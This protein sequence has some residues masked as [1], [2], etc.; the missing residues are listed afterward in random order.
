MEANLQQPC[1][2]K[3]DQIEI[4]KVYVL[5]PGARFVPKDHELIVDHLMKKVMNEPVP[6]LSI[7]EI[8][9]A[10]HSPQELSE[11][12]DCNEEK[13]WYFYSPRDRKYPN[14]IRPNR[15]AGNGYWKATGADKL[16]YYGDKEVGKKKSLVYYEGKPPQGNKTNWIM[17]EYRTTKPNAKR[18]GLPNDMR[19]DDWV[20]CRIYKKSNRSSKNQGQTQQYVVAEENNPNNSVEFEHSN[21]LFD[22]NNISVD[23]TYA[24][25]T[26]NVIPSLEPSITNNSMYMGGGAQPPTAT[27]LSSTE[28]PASNSHYHNQNFQNQIPNPTSTHLNAEEETKEI[29][30]ADMFQDVNDYSFLTTLS[31][32][33][34]A[35]FVNYIRN[36]DNVLYNDN[37]LLPRINES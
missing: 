9:L 23:D 6:Y 29:K 2:T 24:N 36:L 5:P 11:I 35:D 26:P 10:K 28:K 8:D 19:L 13:E 27:G 22:N 32:L 14:G 16:I 18:T 33:S 3:D 7:T 20:L 12:Y 37:Q 21:A 15:A 17:H 25:P 30:L 1:S 34:S 31:D 4:V